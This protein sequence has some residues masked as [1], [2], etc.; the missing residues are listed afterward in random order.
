M[1]KLV[2]VAGPYTAKTS[3]GEEMHIKQA[4]LAGIKLLKMGY[5]PVIP[6]SMYAH[7]DGECEYK[8][9]MEATKSLLT[10][11]EAVLVVG[12]WEFSPGVQDELR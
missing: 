9:F 3:W 7:F 5:V 1:G 8:V 6:H 12:K 2:F 10:V 11:C 4:Q